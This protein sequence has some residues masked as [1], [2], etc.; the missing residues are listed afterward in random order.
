MT[1][2]HYVVIPVLANVT[3]PD[4]LDGGGELRHKR[5]GSDEAPT[6]WLVV[7][8]D[9]A[10]GIRWFRASRRVY[11]TPEE[12]EQAAAAQTAAARMGVTLS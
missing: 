11:D 2:I 4:H 9:Y 6:G 5:A 12:A 1:C 10:F 7:D 8:A 3:K